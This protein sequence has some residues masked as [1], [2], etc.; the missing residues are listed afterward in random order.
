MLKL[1]LQGTK[2][3]IRWFLKTLRRNPRIDLKNTSTF[4]ENKGTEKFK[5]VYTEVYRID[6]KQKV[7]KPKNQESKDSVKDTYCGSGKTFC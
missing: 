7:S 5:R 1:R 4:F 6:S 3:E 2:N